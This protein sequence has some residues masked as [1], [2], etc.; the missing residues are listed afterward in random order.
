MS[1]VS[2]SG[3]GRVRVSRIMLQSLAHGPMMPTHMRYIYKQHPAGYACAV[4]GGLATTEQ[5]VRHFW[6]NPVTDPTH[7]MTAVH[8]EEACST[9]TQQGT[10]VAD[11]AIPTVDNPVHATP[12][13]GESLAGL[14]QNLIQLGATGHGT[15]R[16]LRDMFDAE[17]RIGLDA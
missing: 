14:R 10:P 5:D 4:C 2:C 11:L 7:P 15:S 6:A 12:V 13:V 8:V 16:T 9:A 1:V 3:L 17:G